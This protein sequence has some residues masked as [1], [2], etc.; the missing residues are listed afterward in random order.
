MAPQILTDLLL[1]LVQKFL[2][3]E[4]ANAFRGIAPRFVAPTTLTF[5]Q[6]LLETTK[7]LNRVRIA[8]HA[9]EVLFARTRN[10]LEMRRIRDIEDREEDSDN[11]D[12]ACEMCGRLGGNGNFYNLRRGGVMCNTCLHSEDVTPEVD[13][14]F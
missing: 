4:T 8:A 5:A 2:R 10:M 3:A 11:E 6:R 12:M 9:A 1:D 7:E 14:F 13:S